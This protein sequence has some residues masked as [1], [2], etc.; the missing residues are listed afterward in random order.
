LLFG[1]LKRELI[2]IQDQGVYEYD[3]SRVITTFKQ[4]TDLEELLINL[5]RETNEIVRINYI[6]H[7]TGE[8]IN[9]SQGSSVPKEFYMKSGERLKKQE[10]FGHGVYPIVKQLIS[11][12]I[13]YGMV[14]NSKRDIV[15]RVYIKQNEKTVVYEYDIYT[16]KYSNISNLEDKDQLTLI[17]IENMLKGKCT[18]ISNSY[19]DDIY[20]G[21]DSFEIP[22]E[23]LKIKGLDKEFE[24]EGIR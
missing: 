4:H 9:M 23:V 12:D 22:E 21:R 11:E 1:K 17:Q 3:N 8:K 24:D 2:V 13:E 19:F 20:T 10:M 5:D 15:E 16:K 18:I 6:N 14:S 7:E